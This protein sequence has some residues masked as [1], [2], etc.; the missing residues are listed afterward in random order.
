MRQVAAIS[1]PSARPSSAE[2]VAVT[3]AAVASRSRMKDFDARQMPSGAKGRR[4]E[5]CRERQQAR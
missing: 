3:L 1:E 2:T 5:S 4:F